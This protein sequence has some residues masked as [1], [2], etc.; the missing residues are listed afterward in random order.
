M[1]FRSLEW[2]WP[3]EAVNIPIWAWIVAGSKIF[4]FSS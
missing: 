2:N 3:K 1:G 4:V